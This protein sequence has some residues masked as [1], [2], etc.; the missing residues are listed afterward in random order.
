MIEAEI[1]HFDTARL[2]PAH[3][4]LFDEAE[5]LR[6]RVAEL[7]AALAHEKARLTGTQQ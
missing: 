3:N 4:E 5:R 1:E 6:Y 2:V 7:E